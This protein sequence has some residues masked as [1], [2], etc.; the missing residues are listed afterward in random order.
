MG[1]L[2][3]KGQSV[4]AWVKTFAVLL[5]VGALLALAWWALGEHRAKLTA[6]DAAT[7]AAEALELKAK[8]LAVAE[9]S[10]AKL[11]ADYAKAKTES[12]LFA[13]AAADAMSK[14]KAAR[15]VSVISASTGPQPVRPDA[16]KPA[17]SGSSP[18]CALLETDQGEIEVR[19]ATI[20]TQAGNRVVVGAAEAYRVSPRRWLFGGTFSAPLTEASEEAKPAARAPGWGAGP[21]AGISTAGGQ[22]GVIVATPE[23]RLPVLGGQVFGVATGVGGS[24]QF[25]VSAGIVWRP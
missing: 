19:Q 5:L 17:A 18:A 15:V 4:L 9:Q 14:L 3:D 1:D 11:A 2:I 22:L 23:G 10:N 8:C 12:A 6:Q 24:G 16:T 25:A 13:A 20:Q 7:K 21:L